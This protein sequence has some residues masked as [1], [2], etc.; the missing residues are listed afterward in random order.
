MPS[1][2]PPGRHMPNRKSCEPRLAASNEPDVR[3]ETEGADD[4]NAT[5]NAGLTAHAKAEESAL[6]EQ[7]RRG[8]PWSTVTR[9]GIARSTGIGGP[10]GV[11]WVGRA[12]CIGARH[13]FTGDGRNGLT[14]PAMRIAV[15]A[16]LV[17]HPGR[18]TMHRVMM[19]VSGGGFRR[20]G[21]ADHG[22]RRE[23]RSEH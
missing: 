18:M 3:S 8:V 6:S 10:A 2:S 11:A 21:D 15:V 5:E 20:R 4:R 12:S 14:E 17:D 1:M 13:T 22:C 16:V 23:S 7:T 19:V 9:S